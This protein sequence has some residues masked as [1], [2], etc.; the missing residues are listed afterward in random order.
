MK[1]GFHR[2]NADMGPRVAG[3]V[4]IALLAASCDRMI[5]PR[6]VQIMKDADRKAA[7]GDYLRAINLYEAALDDSPRCA[8]IHYKMALLYDDKMN[9]PLN[10]LHHFK[11]YLTLDP[12]G[13]KAS[14]VKNFM[15]RD[16]VALAT[17]LSGD[18]IVTR[19]EAARLKNENLGL[20]KQVEDRF[21]ASRN[22]SE[23]SDS[24]ESRGR[25]KKKKA[26]NQ[27]YVVQHGDTLFSISR[28]FYKAP[29]RWK[30]I[31]DAN[32]DKIGDAGK[33][34]PGETLTIP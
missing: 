1:K 31:R 32:K 26:G 9:D 34:K 2:F 21:L 11:R 28:K 27:T 5:T 15:K 29:G 22:T 3:L 19:A 33:L 4:L 8:D 13:S 10:A 18:A 12:S 23:K 25:D 14:E 24:N 16:E 17:T 30:E 6:N 20:R 7:Q